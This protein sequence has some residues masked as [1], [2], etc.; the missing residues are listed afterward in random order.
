VLWARRAGYPLQVHGLDHHPLVTDLARDRCR[1]YP[2]ISIDCRDIFHVADGGYDYVHASQFVHH[3]PDP[4]VVPLLKHMLTLC[5]HKLVVNDLLRAPLAYFSTWAFT[6]FATPVFR[7]DARL[8][9]RR[10]FKI[11]ELAALLRAGGLSSFTLRWHFWY[12]VLLILPKE[13]SQVPHKEN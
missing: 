2:E 5:E 10:G 1:D 4:E 9:V 8:S 7:H 13:P 12:R 6:L 11:K 3:F